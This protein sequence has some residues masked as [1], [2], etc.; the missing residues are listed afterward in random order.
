MML[1]MSWGIKL[2]TPNMAL[3]L[4]S[5]VTLTSWS[6]FFIWKNR[7]HQA[8]GKIK[9]NKVYRGLC[10][11]TISSSSSSS[12]TC[13]I[14]VSM[15]FYTWHSRN[16]P[17]LYWLITT[18]VQPAPHSVLE[19]PLFTEKCFFILFFNAW[20]LANKSHKEMCLDAKQTLWVSCVLR[21]TYGRSGDD[22]Q[23]AF[24]LERL[25][26]CQARCEETVYFWWCLVNSVLFNPIARFAHLFCV[27][28]SM[29][30]G[31]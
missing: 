10:S 28:G 22:S 4:T 19:V 1:Y 13:L 17:E 3:P 29:C 21:A 30:S 27:C 25:T 11:G 20:A 9:W 7:S 14:M 2:H 12:P 24:W 23:Y 8:S 6:L 18:A 16:W 26:H 5:S 15:A 31:S